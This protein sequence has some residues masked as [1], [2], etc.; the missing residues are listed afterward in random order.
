[1]TVEQS[2]FKSTKANLDIGLDDPSFDGQ[3]LT[4]INGALSDLVDYGV[5]P[6]EGF[7][8]EGEDETWEELIGQQLDLNR[9]KTWLVLK[10]R[11]LFD[12]PQTSFHLEA[13]NKQIEELTWR[14]INRRDG[15]RYVLAGT[16]E[17]EETIILDGGG[18]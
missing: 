10:V 1:M 2:I 18:A 16:G 14:M 4:Y 13:A 5:G 12:P 3:I 15:E 7:Q 9:L 11:L 17:S 8:I 6:E